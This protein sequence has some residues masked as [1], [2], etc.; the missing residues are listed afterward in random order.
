M[1]RILSLG[2][3]KTDPSVKSVLR[4]RYEL[5]FILFYGVHRKNRFQNMGC[6]SCSEGKNT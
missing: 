5:Y 2:F 3:M 1:E 4:D 6:S